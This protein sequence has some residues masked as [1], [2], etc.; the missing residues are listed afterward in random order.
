MRRA[1]KQKRAEYIISLYNDFVSNRDMLNMYYKVE[2]G[3]CVY[4]DTPEQTKEQR[5]EEHLLD[6]LLGY[7]ENIAKLRQLRVITKNDLRIVAYEFMFVYRN[8]SVRCYL[9]S[10][11]TWC[12]DRMLKKKA[13]PYEGFKKVGNKLDKN[14]TGTPRRHS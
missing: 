8:E 7:F 2:N 5:E 14:F 6:K 12:H 3:E 4:V 1:Y 9:D 10:V 11:D 13:K